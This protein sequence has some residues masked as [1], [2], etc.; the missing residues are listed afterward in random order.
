MGRDAGRPRKFHMLGPPSVVG[1]R[2]QSRGCRARHWSAPQR[3]ETREH[4]GRAWQQWRLGRSSS[5]TSAALPCSILLG[6]RRLGITNLGFTQTASLETQPLTGTLMYLAPEV[7]A[8]QSPSAG[9]D[10]Y[11]L[12]VMLYQ[13]TIGDFRKPLAPGWES[14]IKDPLLARISRM[15]RAAIRPSVS[16]APPIW[17][18]VAHAGTTP[19]QARRTGSRAIRAQIAER[20]LAELGPGSPGWSWR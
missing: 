13:L 14:E 19:H 12:G 11:A 3:P 4:P 15:L 20:K 17:S 7:L 16:T 9:A 1:G 18:S 6:F 2:S 5:R 10:V 8:G